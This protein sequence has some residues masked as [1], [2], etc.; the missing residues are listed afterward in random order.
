MYLL[1]NLG[2]VTCNIAHILDDFADCVLLMSIFSYDLLPEF[3]YLDL[4]KKKDFPWHTFP[5]SCEDV[6]H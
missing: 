1:K 5:G 2:C 6:F 4:E 3:W